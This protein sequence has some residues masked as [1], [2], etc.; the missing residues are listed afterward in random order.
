MR[1][2]YAGGRLYEYKDVP[3]ATYQ[4][5]L[6]AESKGQFVNWHIKPYYDCEEVD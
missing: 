3:P 2:R 4:D 1:I 6:A 5:F